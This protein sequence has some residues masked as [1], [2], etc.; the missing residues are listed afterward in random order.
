MVQRPPRSTR[1]DT[2]FPYATL[3]RAVWAGVVNPACKFMLLSHGFETL[4][5]NRI[6]LKTDASNTR[7]QA[8]I[9]RLVATR[10][11]VFRRHMVL[12]DGHIRDTVSY[13][14]IREAWPPRKETIQATLDRRSAE[15]GER[16]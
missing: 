16:N 7:S 4:G 10:E 2:L 1:T 6:E 12:Q 5:L 11:G 9:T 15:R 3:F 8:A 14:I 13:S